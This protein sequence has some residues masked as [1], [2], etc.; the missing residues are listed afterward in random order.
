MSEPQGKICPRCEAVAPLTAAFCQQCGHG[1]R[2]QFPPPP[3]GHRQPA[4][5]QAVP[6]AVLPPPYQQ[7][8][9]YESP[10]Y[11]TTGGVVYHVAAPPADTIQFL[12]GTH[13]VA[14]VVILALFITG[15]GQMV[16]K[17]VIKGVV[18]LLAAV[19]LLPLTL[20]VGWFVI[21]ITAFIDAIC[22]ANRLNRGEAVRQWQWF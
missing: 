22:I 11:T 18:L 16:N 19:V 20:G 3:L 21:A 8:P 10:P 9:P 7:Q 17:Q 12:A 6:P 13:S 14:L 4:P 15:T 2:T 5:T 1:F